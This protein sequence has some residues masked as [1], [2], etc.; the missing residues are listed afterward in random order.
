MLAQPIDPCPATESASSFVG[1]VQD[2]VSLDNNDTHAIL[3]PT[4][5]SYQ[6]DINNDDNKG[7]NNGPIFFTYHRQQLP[8]ISDSDPNDPCLQHRSNSSNT[9]MNCNNTIFFRSHLGSPTFPSPSFSSS[10]VQPL[11]PSAFS[12]QTPSVATVG[13][14]SIASFPPTSALP[15][16]GAM[17]AYPGPIGLSDPTPSQPNTSSSLPLHSRISHHQHHSIQQQQL[18]QRHPHPQHHQNHSNE[19]HLRRPT[20]PS[21][22]TASSTQQLHQ[23]SPSFPSTL[24]NS[25]PI[26]PYSSHNQS[27]TL[28]YHHPV[29]SA[30]KHGSTSF[31]SWTNSRSSHHGGS[32]DDGRIGLSNPQ[33]SAQQHHQRQEGSRI[34]PMD[35]NYSM[36]IHP[37]EQVTSS[38]NFSSAA[39]SPSRRSFSHLQ[40]GRSSS[41]SHLTLPTPG[42]FEGT[43]PYFHRSLPAAPHSLDNAQEKPS[44]GGAGAGLMTEGDQDLWETPRERE[45]RSRMAGVDRS[46]TWQPFPSLSYTPDTPNHMFTSSPGETTLHMGTPAEGSNGLQNLAAIS[47]TSFN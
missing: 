15:L 21:R 3:E 11:S 25:S 9:L 16:A 26:I 23:S 45:R 27:S 14:C 4:Q 47:G 37:L 38:S 17:P 8:H 34:S 41:S 18:E 39:P 36:S 31:T 12:L 19:T 32:G 35:Y 43:S 28:H 5:D 33:V 22:K 44:E 42:L 20:H 7:N 46:D 1:D 40:Q 24:S 30:T 6:H 13:S 29:E 2:L 10:S